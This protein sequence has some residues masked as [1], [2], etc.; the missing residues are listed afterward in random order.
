MILLN[1]KEVSEQIFRGAV[2]YQ[3]IL[4]LAHSGKIPYIK[5]GRK[6]FFTA[7]TIENYL[8]KQL[9]NTTIAKNESEPNSI[10]PG[11]RKIC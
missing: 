9:S 10:I 7:D 4:R 2:S 3:T 1:S 11:I 6:M 5:V 8:K